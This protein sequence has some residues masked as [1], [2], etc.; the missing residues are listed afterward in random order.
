LLGFSLDEVEPLLSLHDGQACNSAR[1]IAEHKLVDV[2]QR[3][4]DLSMLEAALATLVQRCSTSKGKVSCPLI[5]ALM[6]DSEPV[7]SAVVCA[8]RYAC[9]SPWL[10]LLT[11]LQ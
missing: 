4:Q 8:A 11:G 2:R 9:R 6:E 5:E 1:A 10:L 7:V 3:I